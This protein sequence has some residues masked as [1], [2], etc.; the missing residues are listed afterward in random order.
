MEVLN[1]EE[2]SSP[3]IPERTLLAAVLE[4]AF[5]DLDWTLVNQENTREALAWFQELSNCEDQIFTFKFISETLELTSQELLV[6]RKKVKRTEEFIYGQSKPE[7][8]K[9]RA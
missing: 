6:I 5:R 9:N 4:R 8:K 3:K 7:R 1:A 2:I